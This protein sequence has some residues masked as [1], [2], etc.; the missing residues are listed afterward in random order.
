MEM[1]KKIIC[2]LLVVVLALGCSSTSFAAEQQCVGGFQKEI[3]TMY[4][5]WSNVVV[6][7]GAD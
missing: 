3:I 5:R 2:L 4:G 7:N 1:K 6:A